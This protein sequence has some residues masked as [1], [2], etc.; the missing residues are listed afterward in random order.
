VFGAGPF[1]VGKVPDAGCS[2]IQV[3]TGKLLIR[4]IRKTI[5]NR[6]GL[7]L[8]LTDRGLIRVGDHTPKDFHIQGF[9]SQELKSGAKVII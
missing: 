6:Q 7:F 1:P 9:N 2:E 3:G 5:Q 8:P 4:F